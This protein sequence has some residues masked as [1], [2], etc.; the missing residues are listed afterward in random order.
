[1]GTPSAAISWWTPNYGRPLRAVNWNGLQLNVVDKRRRSCRS[2]ELWPGNSCG[3]YEYQIQGVH[4]DADWWRVSSLGSVLHRSPGAHWLWCSLDGADASF[5]HWTLWLSG[6][7]KKKCQ[8]CQIV[9]WNT[10]SSSNW[11]RTG[12]WWGI[13]T[14][15]ITWICFTR[16]VHRWR[17][18][19]WKMEPSPWRPTL[20][21]SRVVVR[22]FRCSSPPASR[23]K[24][25]RKRCY[26]STRSTKDVFSEDRPRTRIPTPRIYVSG[27]R[28]CS[29]RRRRATTAT[30]TSKH[31]HTAMRTLTSSPATHR[32]PRPVQPRLHLPLPL[33][34]DLQFRF[35]PRLGLH[36]PRRMALP[37]TAFRRTALPWNFLQWSPLQALRQVTLRRTGGT[38][39]TFWSVWGAPNCAISSKSFAGWY[40]NW[41]KRPRRPSRR[42]WTKP[43]PGFTNWRR[44][45][46]F[47]YSRRIS[48]RSRSRKRWRRSDNSLN[49]CFRF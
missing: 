5:A 37:P 26:P 40:P 24:G 22:P 16:W 47:C 2:R 11:T 44:M 28:I 18:W 41:C 21:A 27:S 36:C 25:P 45:R 9:F 46:S 1:M 33:K 6:G 19:T 12:R 42:F 29:H 10:R 20:S 4:Q 23:G 13:T 8:R 32:P 48:T 7:W 3:F 34:P 35:Y 49:F 15:T 43:R 30:A 39:T 14:S 38:T 17:V 31:L